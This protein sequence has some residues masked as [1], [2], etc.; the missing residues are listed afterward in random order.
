[1]EQT[2]YVYCPGHI[3]GSISQVRVL[4]L[5]T[6]IASQMSVTVRALRKIG[7]DAR[8]LVLN[9]SEIQMD[10]GLE[11]YVIPSRKRHPLSGSFRTLAWWKSTKEAFDWADI[12]HWHSGDSVWPVQMDLKYV[13]KMNKARLIEFWGSDIRIP[14][15][16]SHDN[17]V[18]AEFYDRYPKYAKGARE[19]SLTMQS[20]FASRGFSAVISGLELVDSLQSDRF[21]RVHRIRQRLILNDFIPIYPKTDNNVPVVVHM[22]SD[23]TIKGTGYVLEAIGRLKDSCRFEFRL[24]HN[25]S[26][27]KA[28]SLLSD[29]DIMLDQFVI[30]DY[31]LATLEAMAMGKPAICYLKQSVI[32][33]LPKD[34]PVVNASPETLPGVLQRLIE[35]ASLRSEIGRMSRQYVEKYHDSIE[36]AHELKRIYNDELSARR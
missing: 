9:N 35:N 20:R 14:E 21:N 26:R 5:P 17:R 13:E 12:V 27:E 28:L 8:G 36:V 34:F 7:V 33:K 10:S 1:M 30:G 11:S 31:G 18:M 23:K 16:S 32:D 4:H 3:S 15:R 6:N 25:V 2:I 29:A 24:I 19:R 22:P